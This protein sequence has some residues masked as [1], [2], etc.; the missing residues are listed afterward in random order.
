MVVGP[1]NSFLLGG[2]TS[3]NHLT[4]NGGKAQMNDD[5]TLLRHKVRADG[6]YDLF[7]VI[8]NEIEAG[9]SVPGTNDAWWYRTCNIRKVL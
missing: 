6:Q 9:T 1:L 3:A 8:P 5:P 7:P 2:Q 4:V